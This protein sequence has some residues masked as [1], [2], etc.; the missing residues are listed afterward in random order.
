MA[1]SIRGGCGPR[2]LRRSQRAAW[3]VLRRFGSAVLGAARHV[4]AT[5]VRPRV[6]CRSPRPIAGRNPLDQCPLLPRV[7]GSSDVRRRLRDVTVLLGLS[8]EPTPYLALGL[9]KCLDNVLLGLSSLS[10]AKHAANLLPRS[11]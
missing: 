11:T 10:D 1:L 7:A 5:A 4:A 2:R 8:P 9:G 3:M 6:T